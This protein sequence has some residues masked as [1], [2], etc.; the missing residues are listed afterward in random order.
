MANEEAKTETKSP[1]SGLKTILLVGMGC[2]VILFIVGALISVAGGALFKKAGLSFFQSA[3][4]KKTGVKTNLGDLEKG[5]LTFTD[6]ESGAKVEI[7]TG[8]VPDNF[9][10]DFPLY[11]NAKVSGS[12]S[13]ANQGK[14][15]GFWLTFTTSD[16]LDKVVAYYKTN[17]TANGWK[18]TATLETGDNITWTVTKGTL[19]GTVTI[20]RASD[21]KETSI[22]II[23]SEKETTPAATETPTST[24]S[25]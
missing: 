7:G 15:G 19:E 8:K 9:P 6:K 25:E 5:K 1:S 22:L 12:L 21:S 18:T 10:K 13:G 24:G 11:P 20:D 14:S 4:E 23:L 3:L 2:L 17:L 16:A